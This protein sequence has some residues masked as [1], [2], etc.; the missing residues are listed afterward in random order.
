MDLHVYRNSQD[1]W[2]DLRSAAREHGAV[3]AINA[4]TFQELVERITPDVKAASLGQRFVLIQEAMDHCTSPAAADCRHSIPGLTR[5]AYDAITEL[6]AAR[7]RPAEVRAAGAALLGDV[8]E[9]Y[10]DRLR[11]SGFVDPQDLRLLAGSRV[12]ERAVPW[13]QKFSRVVLHALYDLTEAD[14]HLLRCLNEALPE[15]GAV[16]LFNATA[17]VKPTQFAE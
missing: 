9:R 12:V 11:Q 13:L 3:L 16:V 10:D 7:V 5:Y 1:R 2:R 6:K 8:L 4:V 14:F 17:N 15:G